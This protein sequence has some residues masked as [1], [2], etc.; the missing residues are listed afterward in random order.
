MGGAIA[1]RVSGRVP[2][3]ASS[4]FRRRDADGK[5]AFEGN[6]FV[7]RQSTARE[8]F[9][10]DQRFERAGTNAPIVQTMVAD[11]KD[12]TSA[13]VQIPHAT[14]VSLLFDSAVLT[15]MRKWNKNCWEQTRMW[16]GVS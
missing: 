1:I 2:V 7:C 5:T 6:A 11:A 3:R 15:E 13:F 10:A 14:H 12:G 16:C 8:E 9:P 4:R